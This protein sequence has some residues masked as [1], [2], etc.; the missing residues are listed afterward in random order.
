[1][2]EK[3]IIANK[4]DNTINTTIGKLNSDT[5]GSPVAVIR[6]DPQQSYLDVPELL[7]S[8]INETN[9][10]AWEQ[11]KEKIDYTYNNLVL[12]LE[13]LN[14]ETYLDSQV[15][16]WLKE[17]KK[18]LFKP[19]IVNPAC[20]DPVSHGEDGGYTASTGWPFIAALMRCFHDKLDI[21]YH[22][23]SLGEAG[24]SIGHAAAFYSRHYTDGRKV[25]TEAIIEG[26]CG[27]F[28]GGWGFYFVRKYLAEKHPSSHQDDPMKGYDE[29]IAGEY[30]PPGKAENR[31]MVY[32]LNRVNDIK[33]KCRDIEIAD[34]V[35]FKSITLH[36]AITGGNSDNPGDIED[37]PGCILV[38]V[39]RLKV[40]S[41]TMFTNAIKNVGIGL[42]PME[43]AS[44]GSSTGTDWKYSYPPKHPPIMKCEIP[45]MPW[46][47][48]LDSNSLPLRDSDGQYIVD[49][50]YGLTGTI[51]DMVKALMNVNV[52]EIHVV[53]AV[54]ALNMD[55]TGRETSE[56]VPEG[57]AFAALDVVAL[58][59]LCARYLYNNVP[60]AETRQ[61]QKEH[62]VQ[63][64]FIQKVPVPQANS[65]DIVTTEGYDAPLSRYG[66]FQYSEERGLGQQD[67]YAVGWETL[68]EAPIASLQGHLGFVINDEFKEIITSKLYYAV[69]KPLWDI[70]NTVLSYA[71][72]NDSLTGSSYY[73]QLLDGYDENNDGII[74]YEEWGTKGVWL[75]LQRLVAWGRYLY[76]AEEYGFLHGDFF[77]ASRRLK[78]SNE[79]WNSERH[80]F[81]KEYTMACVPELAFQMSK[82]Q[83]ETGDPLYDGMTWGNGK[84]P[85]WQFVSHISVVNSIYQAQTPERIA[86]NSLYGLALQYADKKNN[87]GNYTSDIGI[88]SQA[89]AV[90]N[91]ILAVN[92][93][94]ARLD[95]ILYV[96]EGFGKLNNVSV[97]NVTET[98]DS[99]LLFTAHFNNDQ[100]TW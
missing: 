16:D 87:N 30:I 60:V 21:S 71:R 40:H 45:H 84:W 64:D 26:K 90:S 22:K 53:D 14:R 86:N 72:S 15:K 37:Y 27:S 99:H 63:T 80:D 39:P 100:E 96:P 43:L 67:Y 35:N 38:N 93:G 98:D 68:N 3:V 79:K 69:A 76:T 94:A 23:M 92:N 89:D 34:G 61:L 19:N 28:Y 65:K 8:F 42:Y 5:S 73:S 10:Q 49:R 48:Q 81:L 52:P 18:L 95:F 54:F 51:V 77:A 74:D 83:K 33:A 58:D 7:Q 4:E 56:K 82:A 20:M 91:Y 29:S 6:M 75:P 50:T 13:E 62:R 44:D 11:I 17:G 47:P 24:T 78:Y 1:L 59:H 41:Q 66:L 36:K 46:V 88:Y 57:L 70:Q 9:D 2:R 25:S 12:L 32:D 85:S 55:H 31:L 97:P